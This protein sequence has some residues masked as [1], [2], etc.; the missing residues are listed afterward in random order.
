[1]ITNKDMDQVFHALAHT[2]RR[3]MLDL[4]KAK[5][6]QGVGELAQAFDVSRIAIMNHLK[7]LEE[8]GLIVSQ[9][10]GRK[11]CLYLNTVPIQQV[12]DRWINPIDAPFLERLTSIKEIAEETARKKGKSNESE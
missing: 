10:T 11:R 6:G 8:A 7:V 1:M 12:R 2:T 3:K 4:L 5:P 9:K